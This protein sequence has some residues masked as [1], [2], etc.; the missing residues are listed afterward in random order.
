MT[1]PKCAEGTMVKVT[2][3]ESGKG[4]YLCDFCESLWLEGSSISA[5]TGFM[6]SSYQRGVE[7]EYTL[8]ESEGKDQEH[9]PARYPTYK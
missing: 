5:N 9:R 6:L 2:F 4:A 8:E 7:H 3:K 1:C